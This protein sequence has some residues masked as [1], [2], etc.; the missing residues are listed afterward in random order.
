MG[1]DSQAPFV[2]GENSCVDD[3]CRLGYGFGPGRGAFTAGLQARIRAGT[4]VYADVTVGNFF[5]TGHHVM[6]RE[7]T[8]IGDNVVVGTGTIIDGQV[9]IGDFVKIESQCYIPTHVQ[10][11]SRVFIGPGTILTND[12]NPLK[13][14]DQYK[15]LGPI[16]ED[17]VTVGAGVTI[18]PGVRVGEDAFVAA[19][20]VVTR[21][22]PPGTLAIGVPARH[23]PLPEKLEGRNM[24][25]SWRAYIKE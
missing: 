21:D 16:L 19:G 22:I 5:Q 2:V 23:K 10:I 15:P 6:I 9:I 17:G 4:I 25:L 18:C 7:N 13:H 24:A 20:A 12:P 14:R 3:G 8:R 11:G 1:S